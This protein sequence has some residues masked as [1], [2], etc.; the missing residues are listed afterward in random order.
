MSRFSRLFFLFTYGIPKCF[1]RQPYLYWIMIRHLSFSLFQ[2]KCRTLTRYYYKSKFMTRTLYFWRMLFFR[3][4][5]CILFAIYITQEA[6]ARKIVNVLKCAN[7]Q[8]LAIYRSTGLY[9]IF[10][11][12]TRRCTTGI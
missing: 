4:G 7:M 9:F 3:I 6:R 12:A 2:R 10:F 8:Q 5:L 11:Y 1:C